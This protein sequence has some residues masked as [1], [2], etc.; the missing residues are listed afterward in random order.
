MAAE[1]RFLGEMLARRGAVPADRLEG[2]YAIQREK[3]IDL[4]DLLVNSNVTDEATV[5]RAL[6]EEAQLPLVTSID[7]TTITTELATKLPIAFA[8][9]HKVI[10]VE[11]D[12]A[13]VRV[14]IADPFDT[15]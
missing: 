5:A 1:Q 3:G 8:K 13:H 2:L 9:A 6:A 7:P 11:E 12:E 15:P 10:A 4:V 14:L